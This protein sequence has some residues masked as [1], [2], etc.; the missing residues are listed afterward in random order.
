MPTDYVVFCAGDKYHRTTT[1]PD[2]IDMY[3]VMDLIAGRRYRPNVPEPTR[4]TPKS[5]CSA[6]H[7]GLTGFGK[8]PR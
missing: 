5:P 8:Q 7:I 4:R 3:E 6:R 1:K 2:A